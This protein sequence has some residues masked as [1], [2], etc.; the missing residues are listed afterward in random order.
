MAKV[1][2]RG[3]SNSILLP[4]VITLLM[5]GTLAVIAVS[6]PY[7][8]GD[9]RIEGWAWLATVGPTALVVLFGFIYSRVAIEVTDDD[10]VVRFGFGW[11]T[12]RIAWAN[13]ASVEKLYVQPMKWGGWGYRRAP[14][15]KATA[16]VMRAGE[17][18]KF[19]FADGRIFV[20]TVDKAEAGLTAI[21]KV[22]ST[23]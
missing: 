10:I 15:R 22:L 21:R 16:A 2:W 4:W 14:L 13:I 6:N 23:K 8:T 7:A 17:G 12:K 9:E 20:V 3:S 5:V 18:L 11:P 1:H 19:T